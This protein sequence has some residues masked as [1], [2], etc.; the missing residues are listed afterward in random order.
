MTHPGAIATKAAHKKMKQ[1]LPPSA[2]PHECVIAAIDP[3]ATSGA[4]LFVGGDYIESRTCTTHLER[5]SFARL[6][7]EI[8][9]DA[10]L[11]LIVV[12]EKWSAHGKWGTAQAAGTAAQWGMWQAAFETAGTFKIGRSTWPKFTRVLHATWV[13]RVLGCSTNVG[14]LILKAA[15]VNRAQRL[16]GSAVDHNAADAVCIGIFASHAGEVAAL[17]PRRVSK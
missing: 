15:S 10:E 5:A 1:R 7:I 14:G 8:A 17:L 3:G 13:S 2:T 11:P 4:A 16:T 12:A 9:C 6:A